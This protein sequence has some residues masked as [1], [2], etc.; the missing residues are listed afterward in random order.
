MLR[1]VSLL[2]NTRGRRQPSPSTSRALTDAKRRWKS[3]APQRSKETGSRAEPSW[4]IGNT[5]LKT[6]QRGA[7][8]PI[9]PL[10][11]SSFLHS[12]PPVICR[13]SDPHSLLSPGTKLERGRGPGQ[14]DPH[15][16]LPGDKVAIKAIYPPDQRQMSELPLSQEYKE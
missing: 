11:C 14:S 15:A 10:A 13:S 3:E 6:L 12:D 2:S 4:P 9:L 8:G 1:A 5:S 16:R 7:K